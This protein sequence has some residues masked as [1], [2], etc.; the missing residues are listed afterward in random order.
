[1]LATRGEIFGLSV[2]E[3]RFALIRFEQMAGKMTRD[4]LESSMKILTVKTALETGL[5]SPWERVRHLVRVCQ[6]KI[7]AFEDN[8]EDARKKFA[9][10][11][12]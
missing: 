6:T 10:I 1:M 3:A 12:T 9:K 4:E 11:H 2:Q 7:K 5:L 8:G